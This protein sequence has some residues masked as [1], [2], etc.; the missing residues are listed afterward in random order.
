MSDKPAK[1]FRIGAVTATVWGNTNKE[2]KTFFTTNL[3]RSYR[4]D[5]GEWKQTDSL[6]AGDLL[7]AA[8]AL[9]R[10]EQWISEQ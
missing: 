5:G 7:N 9:E 3:S 8:K 6:N 10:A 2:D 4:D 1:K